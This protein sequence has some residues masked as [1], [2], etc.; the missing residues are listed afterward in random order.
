M[1]WIKQRGPNSQINRSSFWSC[2]VLTELDIR[3]NA[4][5]LHTTANTHSRKEEIKY[6][7]D[8]LLHCSPSRCH[9]LSHLYILNRSTLDGQ[10]HLLPPNPLA[11]A[12][13]PA[14]SSLSHR[15]F[16]PDMSPEERVAHLTFDLNALIFT[17]TAVTL[18]SFQQRVFFFHV[19]CELPSSAAVTPRL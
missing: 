8:Q 10:K 1:H 17:T 12:P 16:S 18:V 6:M 7:R 11:D 5:P 3:A 15:P 13:E 4:F 14:H 2:R 9:K 19:M